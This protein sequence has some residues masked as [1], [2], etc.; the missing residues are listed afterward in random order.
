MQRRLPQNPSQWL[1]T[2]TNPGDAVRTTIGDGRGPH[3]QSLASQ[4]IVA[5][6]NTNAEI[7]GLDDLGMVTPGK[8]ADFVVLD[9]NPLE[10]IL[11]TRRINRVYIRG[12]EVDR[13][14]LRSEWAKAWKSSSN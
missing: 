7:L 11:N 3:T 6:T 9:A 2:L 4:V 5:A 8:S 14:G 1:G 10:N 12:K 13:A